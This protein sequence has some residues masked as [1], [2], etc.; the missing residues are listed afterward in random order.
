MK[1]FIGNSSSVRGWALLL[2]LLLGAGM[3][4]SAC[5]D[6]E[7]PAPTTPAPPP[8]PPPAPEPE[9]EPEPTPEPPATPTGLHVDETTATSITWHWNTV[10]GALG[11][12]VQVSMD[13][14]FDDTDEI[15]ITTETHFTA[16]PVPPETSVYL[17]VRSGTGTPEALAAAVATGSLEGLLLSDWSTHVTGMTTAVPLPPAPANLRVASRGSDYIEWAWDTVEG[18]DGYQSQFSTS[19]DF[20]DSD[21]QFHQGMNMTSRRVSNPD[22][23]SDGYLRLRTYTGTP[24]DHTVRMRTEALKG[25]THQPPPAAP[26]AAPTGLDATDTDDDSITLAWDSVRNADT[27]EVEQREP[28]DD[29]GDASCGGG[30]NVVDDEECVASGLSEGTD[31]DFRVRAVP[32]DDDTAYLTSEWSD[33][34]ET[35]TS[36]TAPVQPTEPT[37]GGMGDLNVEWESTADSITFLWDRVSGAE[38]ETAVLVTYSD[39]AEPCEGQTFVAQGRS[40]SQVVPSLARGNVRGLCVQTTDEDNRGLSFAWGA[41]TPVAPTAGTPTVEDGKTTSMTWSTINV[42]EDFNYAV[43]LVADSGRENGMFGA[44]TTPTA[45]ALQKACGD[46]MLLD[47]GLADVSLEGLT[48][49]VDSGIRHFTGYTLCLQYSN[50][51]GTTDWAVPNDG[52]NLTE[53]Q[54]TPATPPAPRFDR[55]TN[56]AAG[57][58]RT[59]AW[60]IPVRNSTDVPREMD[61]FQAI[62]IHYPVRYDHDGDGGGA[63]PT[64]LRSTPAPT[65]AACGDT[66]VTPSNLDGGTNPWD[67]TT[68]AATLGTSLEGV[69]AT[70]AEITIPANTGENVGVRLCVRATRS[71]AGGTTV[72]NGPWRIG[73]ATT[74]TKQAPSFQASP[75]IERSPPAAPSIR[76]TI[77]L[78]R[79]GPMALAV[80]RIPDGV[81]VPRTV[82]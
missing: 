75:W 79:I 1:S 68:T 34:A 43:R 66:S 69:T 4:I 74:I 73:G 60:T 52:T 48:E 82:T 51:A 29:W 41:V 55:G 37:T 28:G 15:A 9:P 64:A 33:I 5:G 42:V 77:D 80:W 13:E 71:S 7:V 25:P 36:G 70:S 19:S 30:D 78:S 63:N 2:A 40:T 27:Y 53:I 50:D 58:M 49:T 23:E 46:G 24:A 26:L 31:Y 32:A 59:L 8:A 47:S 65:V 45:N 18:V 11:Y 61:G 12:A 39:D 35:R 10:E 67:Q 56:N 6:E 57:D 17:R 54:T 38:Y 16:T 44:T 21:T 76:V 20:S 3:M 22:A 81:S 72:V 62:I 14:M